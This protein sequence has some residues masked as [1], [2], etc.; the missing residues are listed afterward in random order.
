MH[1]KINSFTLSLGL[2]LIIIFFSSLG[3]YHAY[4]KADLPLKL[5]SKDSVLVVKDNNPG[6]RE[7]S[8]SDTLISINNKRFSTRD[9]IEVFIDGFKV[10][11]VVQINYLKNGE[12][13]SAPVKLERFYSEF[14]L[15]TAGISGLLL[16]LIGTFVL[17]KKPCN[18]P[19]RLLY[20]VNLI[21][22]AIIMMTW[23]NYSVPPT[24]ID[25]ILHI[26]FS[27]S[28]SLAPALFVHFTL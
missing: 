16:I 4:S 14:Y 12:V 2:D 8:P 21:T 26:I 10:G 1:F 24:I 20:S 7:F 18:K 27:F 17:W 15:I 22:A 6:S 19:A 9:E 3:I 5:I 28:Y 11:S 13:F 25:N 23:S